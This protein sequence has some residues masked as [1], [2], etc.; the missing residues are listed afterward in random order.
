M[1]RKPRL[2]LAAATLAALL[3]AAPLGTASA[4]G[5]VG[6][7]A[8]YRATLGSA[9]AESGIVDAQG[10]VLY[11][12]AD[13]CEGWTSENRTVLRIA[14]TDGSQAQ[15]DWN[16]TTWESKDGRRMRFG[17]RDSRDGELDSALRGSALLAAPG[18][19]GTAHFVVPTDTEMALPAGTIFPTTHIKALI[20]AARAG[21]RNLSATVF[22]GASLDNPYTVGAV[23]SLAPESVRR[24]I[25]DKS[26][27]DDSSVW[28]MR[29]A[30]FAHGD[31]SG[32]PQ[33]EIGI[34]YREDGIADA[35]VHDYVD[36]E[37]H[38]HLEE[39]ELLP[40]PDC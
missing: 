5:L 32:I 31:A 34:T 15:T 35:I 27:L 16:Y 3:S 22:D 8:I 20:D 19:A 1:G 21:R 38:L 18:K 29:L 28:S 12:F 40:K 36:F 4:A 26:G 30:Y 11:R 39:V 25:A 14:Y 24:N 2:D 17:M 13:A 37:L 7:Q 6:H 10:A 33:F 23:L 9:S